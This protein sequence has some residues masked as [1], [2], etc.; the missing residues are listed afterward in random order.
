MAAVRALVFALLFYPSTL[1]YVLAG[2]F[3]SVFG[4]APMRAVVL[5]WAAFHNWLSRTVG[6]VH[7]RI[8]GTIPEGPHLIA[9][10]HQSMFETIEML[11]IAS[12]PI[13]VLKRELADMPLFGWM[14]RRWGIIRVDREAGAS[15]VRDMLARAKAARE[16]KRPVVI[17]PEGT[18]VAVGESPPL[19]AGFAGLYRALGLPVVPIAMDSGRLWGRSLPKAS[20]TVRFK[21]GEVSPAGLDRKEIEAR[22][23][24]AINA[25]E[26]GSEARA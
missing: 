11:R 4:T 7:I 17:F 12:V 20:G 16:S 3:A 6:N 21:V 2:M 25:L 1:A 15:A 8:E 9:V 26:S 10:K 19:G 13:V 5:G 22:V 23:H 18:R 24:T 14:T